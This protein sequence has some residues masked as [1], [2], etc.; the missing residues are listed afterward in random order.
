MVTVNTFWANIFV[1]LKNVDTG[2]IHS[3][4]KAR[5]LCSNY[6]N[7]V[8]LCVT[9]TETEYIYSTSPLSDMKEPESVVGLL[10]RAEG[11]RAEPGFV[12]GLI[13]Y[14]RFPAES[15]K[16]REQALVLARILKKSMEQHRV[17][18]MFPDETV[19]LGEVDD[20]GS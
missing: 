14:P 1:G 9:F 17:T 12:V 5:E 8:G 6:V 15:K 20:F 3:L 19:M 11:Y 2:V 7:S 10:Y 18:I 13:N 16:I 4:D